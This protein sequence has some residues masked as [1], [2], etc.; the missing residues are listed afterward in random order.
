MKKVLIIVGALIF[1]NASHTAQR[2]LDLSGF[3][4]G[5][6][7]QPGPAEVPVQPAFLNP[8]APNLQASGKMRP[9]PRLGKGKRRPSPLPSKQPNVFTEYARSYD[10]LAAAKKADRLKR[11][12]TKVDERITYIEDLQKMI[13]ALGGEIQ[14]DANRPYYIEE[15]VYGPMLEHEP[16]LQLAYVEDKVDLL[17]NQHLALRRAQERRVH[18]GEDAVR[19]FVANP[20]EQA[21]MHA[22]PPVD[23]DVEDL[24]PVNIDEL[25]ALE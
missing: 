11:I 14:E 6:Q 15:H 3:R 20:L 12:A 16:E 10:T 24:V 22:P 21:A 5:E 2:A 18:F 1:I 23:L 7:A 8:G 19:E 4:L 17:E 25:L 9:K 13:E